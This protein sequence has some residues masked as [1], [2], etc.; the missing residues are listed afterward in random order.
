MFFSLTPSTSLVP[1]L[2]VTR[3]FVTRRLYRST[4][5]HATFCH[6]TICHHDNLS[7]RHFVTTTF[8]HHDNL[9]PRHFVTTT[10][11]HH[12]ILSPR[13]FVTR[14][15]VTTTI[16]HHDNLSL[17]QFVTTTFCHYDNL[18]PNLTEFWF[19]ELQVYQAYSRHQNN[20]EDYSDIPIWIR[21]SNL[22]FLFPLPCFITLPNIIDPNIT[23]LLKETVRNFCDWQLNRAGPRWN[24]FTMVEENVY[25]KWGR[26]KS[27]NLAVLEY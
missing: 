23:N 20:F 21:F 5:C 25:D 14:Q 4:F 2:F 13:L 3:Q 12:D 11:C 15:F 27:Q 9:S 1:R 24:I 6:A 22:F 10:I 16:C 7:L 17:R 19:E 18:S 26:W 8:C